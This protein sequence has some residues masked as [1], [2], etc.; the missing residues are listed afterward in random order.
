METR[1]Q[2]LVVDVFTSDVMD[3]VLHRLEHGTWELEREPRL[4]TEYNQWMELCK[5]KHTTTQLHYI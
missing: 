5:Q 3:V 1:D 4:S 2:L